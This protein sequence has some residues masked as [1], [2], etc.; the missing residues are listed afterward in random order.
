MKMK[1]FKNFKIEPRSGDEKSIEPSQFEA[2]QELIKKQGNMAEVSEE[3]RAQ[4]RKLRMVQSL[5]PTIAGFFIDFSLNILSM[6]GTW[7]FHN[8]RMGSD[9]VTPIDPNLL[10][11]VSLDVALKEAVKLK[12]VKK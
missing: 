9:I 8:R 10:R 1:D 11:S 2:F 3:N 4:L 6:Q 7:N 12:D 5:D